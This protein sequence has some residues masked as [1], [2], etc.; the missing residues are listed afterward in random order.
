MYDAARPEDADSDPRKI[1]AH[2]H[3]V[4]GSPLVQH[5]KRHHLVHIDPNA[6]QD[7]KHYPSAIGADQGVSKPTYRKETRKGWVVSLSLS[8][9]S[10]GYD[11]KRRALYWKPGKEHSGIEIGPNFAISLFD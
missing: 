5:Q 10:R 4:H 1:E 8:R 2:R 9:A 3:R 11:T 6:N 7:L